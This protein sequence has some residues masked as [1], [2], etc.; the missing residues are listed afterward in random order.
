MNDVPELKKI[1][2]L[3]DDTLDNIAVEWL[4]RNKDAAHSAAD[5]LL[6]N[7][8]SVGTWFQREDVE[9]H[10]GRE[11]TDAEWQSVQDSWL[12][13]NGIEEVMTEAG[14]NICA[15]IADDISEKDEL[16]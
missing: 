6:R 15:D 8:E 2:D 9:E 16:G 4:S 10:L 5:R 13:R 11:L 1:V 14:N 7:T 3:E 12:W